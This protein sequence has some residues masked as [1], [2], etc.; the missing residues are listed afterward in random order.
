MADLGALTIKAD[1]VD[2]HAISTD[3]VDYASYVATSMLPNV[4]PIDASLFS[5]VRLMGGTG[6]FVN[7]TNDA[8]TPKT[9]SGVTRK[10]G[11]A[12]GSV[13]VRILDRATGAIY[14]ETVSDGSGN[15]NVTLYARELQTFTAVAYDNADTENAAVVDLITPV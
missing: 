8:V 14:A 10:L 2:I 11:V 12:V 4:F 15:F 5:E 7:G 6:P 3:L 13:T 1:T 9:I